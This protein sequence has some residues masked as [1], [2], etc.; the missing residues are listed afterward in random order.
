MKLNFNELDK[1][2]KLEI[3]SDGKETV[4][5]FDNLLNQF[6]E[7]S[8]DSPSTTLQPVS[9]LLLDINMPLVNGID[10]LK[11]IKEKFR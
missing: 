6:K 3:F 5:F 10:A 2:D 1:P 8:R 11:Q 9:L 7:D 4:E